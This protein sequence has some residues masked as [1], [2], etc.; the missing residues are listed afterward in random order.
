MESQI[1]I[2]DASQIDRILKEESKYLLD[3]CKKIKKSGCN[4]LLIQKSILRDSTTEMSLH[5]LAKMGI[6]V[7]EDIERN[8]IE[9]ISKTLGCKPV[10]H[11]D[12]LR[13]EK[14]GSAE[15]VEEVSVGEEKIVR[16]TGIKD[17]GKTATILVRASNKLVLDEADRSLHDAFCVIRS[18][19]KKKF[20]ISGGGAPE[21]EVSIQLSKYSR[22][23]QGSQSVCFKAFAD[24]LEVIPITLSENAGMKP[25][26]IVTELRNLHIKGEV[27]RNQY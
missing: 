16:V 11:V 3:I 9:F 27:N 6:M 2:S 17:K 15:V 18:L 12:H 7:I 24:S 20:V 14:L 4:V 19:V 22:E 13:A 26:E 23:L 5:F 8:E 21:M 25:I 10:S 1:V